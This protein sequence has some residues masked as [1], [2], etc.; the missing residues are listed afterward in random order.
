MGFYDAGNL[1]RKKQIFSLPTRSEIYDFMDATSVWKWQQNVIP[2]SVR[3]AAVNK[4]IS[5]LI[6]F[7]FW[8]EILFFK[9]HAKLNRLVAFLS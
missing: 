5:F 6:I 4:K 7:Y 2:R 1:S 9:L 3:E 8:I